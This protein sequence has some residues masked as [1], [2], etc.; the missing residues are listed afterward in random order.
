MTPHELVAILDKHERWLAKKPGGVRANLAM[1]DLQGMHLAG[2]NPRVLQ[3]VGRHHDRLR[4]DQRQSELFGSVRRSYDQGRHVGLQPLPGRPAGRPYAG[5]PAEGS[6]PA[7]GGSARRRPARPPLVRHQRAEVG[8]HRR[9]FRRCPAGARQPVGRRHVGG[10]H[11]GRRLPGRHHDGRQSERRQRQEHQPVQGRPERR[12]PV[13]SQSVRR[14]PAR[15][16]PGRSDSGR[17]DPEECRPAGREAGRSRSVR[18]RLHRRQHRAVGGELLAEDPAQPGEPLQ[19]DQQQR[20]LRAARRP[21]VGGSGPYRSQRRQSVRR[22]PEGH[23]ARR[24]Q[25]LGMR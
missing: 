11:V 2:S 24:R 18:S 20:R 9:Q 10:Q 22:Q 3:A 13:R 14:D 19:L 7:G 5:R 15:L 17:G 12:Q 21:S 23:Q 16:Q 25:C 4:H 1:I 6:H 8:S